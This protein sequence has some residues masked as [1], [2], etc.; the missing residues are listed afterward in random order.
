METNKESSQEQVIGF[1]SS[2]IHSPANESLFSFIIKKENGEEACLLNQFDLV[3]VNRTFSGKTD[4]LYATVESVTSI[5]DAPD[6]IANFVSQNFGTGAMPTSNRM[7]FYLV[8][9]RVLKNDNNNY[10]P[11]KTGDKVYKVSEDDA[12]NAL[13]QGYKKEDYFGV[14]RYNMYGDGGITLSL[15]LNKKYIVGPDAVHLNVS[16]MSGVAS[17]TTKVLTILRELYLS[18]DKIS[19]VIFNTKDRD[20][21]ELRAK[22]L[23]ELE[24]KDKVIY[25]ELQVDRNNATDKWDNEITVYEPKS[26]KAGKTSYILD[27]KTQRDKGNIDLLTAMDPDD[28][29]TMDSCVKEIQEN[30]ASDEF[31]SWNS[32]KTHNNIGNRNNSNVY[33]SSWKKYKRVVGRILTQDSLT[34]GIFS[35]DENKGKKQDITNKITMRLSDKDQSVTVIDIAPLDSL[36]QGVVFGA[37]MREIKSF[38]ADKERSKEKRVAVFIDEFNKYASSD[39][40]SQNPILQTLIDIAEAGRSIGLGLIT[41]EQSFSIIHRRIKANYANLL[42][43]RTGVVELSQP[44]YMMIPDSYKQRIATFEHGDA[45]LYAT[46]LNSGLIAASFPDKFY[47]NEDIQSAPQ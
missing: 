27:F 1:V 41:A 16:G 45:I 12:Y 42:I 32:L 24:E 36:Q 23:D 46:Y 7:G 10:F 8:S 25:S 20:L 43:G 26:G 19:I 14:T 21:L 18:D 2:T 29:G 6:H 4:C 13:Y 22:L 33:D 3:K 40:P 38:C 47:K 17:K 44:D 35:G 9:A 31:T 37:V 34:K 15:K 11:V 28:S 39:L 30:N 5:S